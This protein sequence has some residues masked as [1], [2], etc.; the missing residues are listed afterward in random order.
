[1]IWLVACVWVGDEDLMQRVDADGDGYWS[2]EVGGFDC[3]DRDPKVHPGA[4]EVCNGI[5]DDCR[6]ANDAVERTWY[7]DADGDGFGSDAVLTCVSDTAGWSLEPGDCDDDHAQASPGA[8]EICADGLDNDCDGRVDC[9]GEEGWQSFGEAEIAILGSGDHRKLGFALV[10]ADLDG[11]GVP[12]LL[13][14]EYTDVTNSANGHTVSLLPWAS[15]TSNDGERLTDGAGAVL[16]AAEFDGQPGAELLSG[17]GSTWSWTS[18]TTWELEPERDGRLRAACDVDGDGLD[19]A[20]VFDTDGG[21][22][23]NNAVTAEGAVVWT[24]PLRAQSIACGDVDGDGWTDLLVSSQDDGL[25]Q[26]GQVRLFLDPLGDP[27]ETWWSGG[28]TYDQVGNTVTLLDLDGDGFDDV[29]LNA[30]GVSDGE[31]RGV[32][33]GWFGG[34]ASPFGQTDLEE[35]EFGVHGAVSGTASA[36]DLNGD[37]SEELLIWRRWDGVETV[38]VAEGPWDGWIASGSL[39]RSL[40]VFRHQV[41]VDLDGDG[42]GDLVVADYW[43]STGGYSA[44]IV[45]GVFGP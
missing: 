24:T 1:M 30:A 25:M 36:G 17:D 18:G 42:F 44:G 11:D 13:A 21:V 16:F 45:A 6:P 40:P 43:D 38:A 12:E 41:P 39:E 26:A 31:D 2:S 27:V 37:G 7:V 20:L 29:V 14:S 19:E 10:V 23:L 34:G 32:S 33:F 4:D 28:Q 22:Y 3:D 8:L 15:G 35:A 5:D 9:L